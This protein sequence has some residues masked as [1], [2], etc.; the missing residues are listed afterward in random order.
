MLTVRWIRITS[1][2]ILAWASLVFVYMGDMSVRTH[3]ILDPLIIASV[4][5]VI[6]MKVP[7]NNNKWLYYLP[8]LPLLIVVLFAIL[9]VQF[10]I[11]LL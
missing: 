4:M 8:F 6:F 1:S 2:I 7:Y 5:P 11:H 10:F 3:A 9:N